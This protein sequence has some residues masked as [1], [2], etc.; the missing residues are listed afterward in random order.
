MRPVTLADLN[1]IGGTSRAALRKELVAAINKHCPKYGID[2]QKRMSMFLA[3][4]APETGGFKKLEESLSYSA[5]RLKEVWP[6]RFTTNA[7]ARQ[8]A[9]NPQKLA[10]YVY[11]NRLGNKGR[12]NA[13]WMYRGSG[14][15]Q[16][17]GYD[18]FLA[19]EKV[20]GL[21]VT[22]RPDILRNADEGVEAACIFWKQNKLERYADKGDVRGCRIKVNGGTNGLAH[23]RKAYKKAV[24]AFAD[25]GK[26]APVK[27]TK[28]NPKSKIL[29]MFRPKQS[30]A[31]TRAVVEKY[32][33][34]M[35]ADRRDDKVIVLFVPGYY[36]S[37]GKAGV[38]DRGIYDDAAFVITPEGVENFNAN[39]D[40]SR[41]RK[42][43]A[44][45][46]PMQA[47]R[48]K[49]GRHGL[50]RPDGGYP[51]FRQ[52]SDITVIRDGVG[53]DTDSASSR[54]WCN[55]H[56]GGVNGTSSLG[57]LTHPPQQWP[58]YYA[59][60]RKALR[61]HKQTT[62]YVLIVPYE[63]GKAPVDVSTAP[64]VVKTK[65][66]TVKEKNGKA[67]GKGAVVGGAVVAGG[68]VIWQKWG[69]ISA[70]FETTWLGGLF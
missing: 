53:E 5:K 31:I 61:V 55:N 46:K 33:H 45:I 20:T 32:K 10:N 58:E 42:R 22:K 49:P 35:P 48:Y 8:Y 59:L 38:N 30:E 6:R 24:D 62:F 12:P 37:M 64:M 28:R 44:T 65:T 43:I 17:T 9:N 15:F 50:S 39:T 36:A 70:W 21:P 67:T 14:L 68:G 69:E 57:C 7:K 56:R 27:K 54:F 4:A 34:L 60:V 2:T 3:M 51:A 52:N 41:F 63:G 40:P 13:G 26:S 29:P 16:T 47:V 11:G 23:S 18:N 25:G 19:V 1:K 66:V